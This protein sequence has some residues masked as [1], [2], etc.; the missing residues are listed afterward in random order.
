[1]LK[2]LAEEGLIETA[3]GQ[4]TRPV[5]VGSKTKRLLCLNKEKAQAIYDCYA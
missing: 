1:L 3:D 4:N 5:R 2:S